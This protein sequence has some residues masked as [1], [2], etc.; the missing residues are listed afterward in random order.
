VS[1][2]SVATTKNWSLWRLLAMFGSMHS[3]VWCKPTISQVSCDFFMFQQNCAPAQQEYKTPGC[4]RMTAAKQPQPQQS[5]LQN[6]R[7]NAAAT[8][9]DK[10][11]RYGDTCRDSLFSDTEVGNAAT[12]LR[13]GGIFDDHTITNLLHVTEMW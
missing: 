8:L 9:P 5:W 10:N 12:H 13:S 11:V 4:G 1:I 6:S 2:Q 7:C 3:V